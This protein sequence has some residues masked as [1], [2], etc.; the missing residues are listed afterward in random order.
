[1]GL[2]PEMKRRAKRIRALVDLVRSAQALLRAEVRAA[3]GAEE[4]GAEGGLR[5]R[6][7]LREAMAAMQREMPR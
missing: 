3:M 2:T 6:H 4:E 1:M 7:E 5:G